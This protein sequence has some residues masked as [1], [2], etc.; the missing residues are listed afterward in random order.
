MEMFEI[1][2][3]SG[4][5]LHPQ[6]VPITAAARAFQHETSL[7]HRCQHSSWGKMHINRCLF[8]T[9]VCGLPLPCDRVTR[10]VRPNTPQINVYD[11]RQESIGMIT[12]TGKRLRLV[13][14]KSV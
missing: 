4:T 9:L 3:H 5:V 7:D 10:L 2:R 11:R 14:P 8:V 13:V 12:H 1:Q 6:P